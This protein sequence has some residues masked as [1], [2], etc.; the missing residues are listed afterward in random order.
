MFLEDHQRCQRGGDGEGGGGGG[1]GGG[2]KGGSAKRSAGSS[3]QGPTMPTSEGANLDIYLV[4]VPRLG[5]IDE[6]VRYKTIL[7][8]YS[9]Q[10]LVFKPIKA[11]VPP[12]GGG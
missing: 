8:I 12:R 1:G 11:P 7:I 6:Q 3:E 9:Y 10:N 2:D 5:G 4:T